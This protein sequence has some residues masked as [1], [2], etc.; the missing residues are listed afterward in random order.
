MAKIK[1]ET[2]RLLL[3]QFEVEDAAAVLEFGS[4]PEVNRYTGDDR[5]ETLDDALDVIRNTWHADYATYGYGRLAVEVKETGRVIGFCGLK[6]LPE[7]SQ[8]D[9][10]Y[11]FLP[12]FWGQGIATECGKAALEHGRSVLGLANIMAIAM[13][14]NI[15]SQRVLEKLGFEVAE[16]TDLDGHHVYIYREAGE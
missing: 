4:H 15:G 1:I 2:S 3:R 5:M 7:F 8:P 11:R 6:F 10:G 13:V 16:E 12:E 9:I 14:E